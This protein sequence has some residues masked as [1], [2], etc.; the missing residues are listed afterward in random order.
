MVGVPVPQAPH[1]GALIV[2]TAWGAE[3]AD[4]GLSSLP[5]L[6]RAVLKNLYVRPTSPV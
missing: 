3:S 5:T 1:K 6:S 2:V 4:G